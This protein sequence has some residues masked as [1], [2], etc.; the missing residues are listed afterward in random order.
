MTE[1]GSIPGA[2]R[3][4]PPSALAVATLVGA[5]LLVGCGGAT[6]PSRP[7]SA[8]ASKPAPSAQVSAASARSDASATASAKPSAAP[9]WSAGDPSG[10]AVRISYASPALSGLPLYAALSGG[11]FGRR[12]LMVTMLKLPSTAA[13]T[14]LSKGEI[15][16][17]NQPALAIQGASR[18]LPFK[19]VLS[20]WREAP[21]TLVGKSELKSLKDLKGKVVA[22]TAVG[23]SPY[24]YLEAALTKVG[25][26]INSDVKVISSRGTEDSFAF[27][28]AGKV[29]ATVVSPPFDAQAEAQGFHQIA[30]LGEALDLPYVGLGTTTDYIQQHRPVVVRTIRALLDADD[31]LKAHPDDAASLSERY[32]GT[33]PELAKKAVA[34]MLP[35]L[36]TTGET[37]SVGMQQALDAQA[38]V[39]HTKIDLKPSELVDYGPLQEAKQMAPEE[40]R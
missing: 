34:T 20:L 31:W 21:W 25:M 28:L 5:L 2:M 33:K 16:M 15:D 30:F 17:V 8:E 3:H 13:I 7:S 24:L 12:H 32:V 40:K 35:L 27:L 1:T 36:T 9:Q 37:T 11:F 23:N 38:Q 22:T 14:A 18:G 4:K 19:V 10:D 29:D 39:T 26:N 6:G